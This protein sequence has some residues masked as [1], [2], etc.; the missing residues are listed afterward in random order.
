MTTAY[1]CPQ[2][3]EGVVTR[4]ARAGRRLSGLSIPDDLALLTCSACDEF[5]LDY[6]DVL[7]IVAARAAARAALK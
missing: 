3:G 6:E 7:A 4:Q 5:F 1:P 2:C